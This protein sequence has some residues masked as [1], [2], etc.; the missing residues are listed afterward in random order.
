MVEAHAFAPFSSTS[1]LFNLF[2]FA[3][4]NPFTLVNCCPLEEEG[5]WAM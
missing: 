4:R 5:R 3:V 1:C 2:R